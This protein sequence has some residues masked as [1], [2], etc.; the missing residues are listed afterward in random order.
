MQEATARDKFH[1]PACGAEAQWN[2]G[3]Q[4]LVCPYCG[5]I[6]PGQN[7][8]ATG[9]VTEHD[10]ATALRDTPDEDRGWKAERTSV[11]CQSCQAISV[12]DPE[13]V[14]QRCDFC[15]S[16]QLV[17]YEQIR[18]PISPESLLPFKVTETA[19][20]EQIRVWYGNRWLAHNALKSRAL[21]DTLRGVYVP[22]WTF[23]ARV[24][25]AW[26]AES[27]YY[28]YETETFEDQGGRM[29]TRR[30]QRVRWEP[31]AGN[32]NHFFDDELVPG[33]KGVKESLL[34]QVEPFPT[35]EVAPYDVKFLAGWV[36]EQY[37]IDLRTAAQRSREEMDS[38]TRALCAR[39]V[40][41]DTC[42]N[43]QVSWEYSGQTFKHVLCPIWLLSYVYGPRSFQVVVNGYTGQIA[44]E[45]PK[46]WLKIFILVVAILCGAAL[47]GYFSQR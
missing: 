14:G 5:V 16:S 42:R 33:T 28:Y 24:D 19:V 20:R 11:K 32:L 29:Q 26:T 30:V 35:Q 40:P 13:H 27:G 45:Y 12:F 22:Y 3:K 4:A 43:L 23:D 6:A 8:P 1:C 36:V 15:G 18:A 41:G 10:L 2:P 39:Q 38:E 44:G 37:Q 31:S 21:T 17:P 25:A 46:S 47:V 9:R 34:R 7:D